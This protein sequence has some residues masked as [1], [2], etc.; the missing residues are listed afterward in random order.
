MQLLLS[1]DESFKLSNKTVCKHKCFGIDE[2]KKTLT[3]FDDIL[4]AVIGE[5]D[6]Q[7]V[8]KEHVAQ[9]LLLEQ[10][11]SITH[12]DWNGT[13]PSVPLEKHT[14]EQGSYIWLSVTHGERAL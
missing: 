4:K 13:L 5:F 7:S 10:N 14:F 8:D 9:Q 6:L 3:I 12:N 1:H 11:I 2:Q